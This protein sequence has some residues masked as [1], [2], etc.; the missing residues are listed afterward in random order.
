MPTAK[1]CSGGKSEAM[2]GKGET[3]R[4]GEMA[5]PSST[6]STVVDIASEVLK[7]CKN[8]V[9][10]MDVDIKYKNKVVG[11]THLPN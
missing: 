3:I 2:D 5:K 4:R 6:S 11:T 7:T 1:K 9:I 10:V 8:F